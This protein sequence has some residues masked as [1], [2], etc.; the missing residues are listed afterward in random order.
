MLKKDPVDII[1]KLAYISAKNGEVPVGAV[2]VENN[3]IISGAFN[4][5]EKDKS[6]LSHAEIKA[7]ASA[8][9][10]KKNWRLDN[11]EL[12]VTLEPCGMCSGAIYLSR[13]KKV[14][15]LVKS[16]DFALSDL[17]YNI[18]VINLNKTDY[19]EQLQLFFKKA[20]NIKRNKME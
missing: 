16:N 20:R 14:Y 9:K 13:I 5:M 17:P 2:I 6:S 11:C 19:L 12:Y 7:I 1:I 10:K 3:K 18:E 15:F 4:S 8:Q